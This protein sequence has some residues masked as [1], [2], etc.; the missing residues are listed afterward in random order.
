MP[1][2]S[3]EDTQKLKELNAKYDISAMENTDYGQSDRHTIN[4]AVAFQI[5]SIIRC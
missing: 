5:A 2:L 3:N 1:N 4:S